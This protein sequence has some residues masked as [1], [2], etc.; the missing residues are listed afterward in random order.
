MFETDVPVCVC[1]FV[2]VSVRISKIF[3]MGHFTPGRINTSSGTLKILCPVTLQ[4]V[5]AF[6]EVFIYNI[7]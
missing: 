5:K 6:C 3:A 1:L 2:C 7:T 4:V